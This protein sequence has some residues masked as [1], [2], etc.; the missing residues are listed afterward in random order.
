[1][2]VHI[3]GLGGYFISYRFLRA[4]DC[5]LP[6]PT[7]LLPQSG[8]SQRPLVTHSPRSPTIYRRGLLPTRSHLAATSNLS[9]RSP[10]APPK[11]R[12]PTNLEIHS[13]LVEYE[14]L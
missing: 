12:S 8:S 7:P 5:R 6:Y 3:E 2:W 14:Y 1:L 13:Q 11:G 9:V 4:V 10:L